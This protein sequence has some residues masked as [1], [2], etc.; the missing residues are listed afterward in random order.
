M[1]QELKLGCMDLL[2]QKN[3]YKIRIINTFLFDPNCPYVIEEIYHIPDKRYI[4]GYR[5]KGIKKEVKIK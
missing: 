5:T 3:L 4:M 2:I 1:R